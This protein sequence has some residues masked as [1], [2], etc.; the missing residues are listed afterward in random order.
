LKWEHTVNDIIKNNRNTI[1]KLNLN[2]YQLRIFNNIA[3]CHTAELG[4]VALTCSDCNQVQYKYHSCRNRHCPSCQGGKTEEWIN[5]QQKYLLNV[6]YFHVVFT[7]PEELRPLC[8]FKPRIM[9]NLLFKASWETIATLSKDNKHLGAQSGMTAV[10]HTWSQNLGIHPHLH[11][12]IPGGGVTKNGSWKYTKS[13]GKYL[14]PR[15]IMRPIFRAIVM[16]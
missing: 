3:K 12:I 10:L 7:L 5:R 13:K 14:F 9:Y 2:T 1:A 8:L 15:E 4:G 6:P 11:C 16:T